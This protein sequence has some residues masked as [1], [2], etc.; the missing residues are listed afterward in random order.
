MA[1]SRN[2]SVFTAG[3]TSNSQ[4]R[5]QAGKLSARNVE[6]RS[7]CHRFKP[8]WRAIPLHRQCH[9]SRLFQ[10]FV[11]QKSSVTLNAPAADA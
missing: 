2:A 3:R 5:T 4:S 7:Y 6:S 10:T 1:Y 8:E 9:R 11:M